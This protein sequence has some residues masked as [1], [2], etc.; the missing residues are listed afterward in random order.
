MSGD[1][2][3]II[4][5]PEVSLWDNTKSTP[6]TEDALREFA[7]SLWK[8]K[9]RWGERMLAEIKANRRMVHPNMM[10]SVE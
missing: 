10:K 4:A 1:K 9:D 8:D 6:I 5:D 2:K 7:A 3:L